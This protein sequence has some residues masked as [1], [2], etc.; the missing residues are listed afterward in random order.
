M[1]RQ[2][3]LVGS[4]LCLLATSA[5]FAQDDLQLAATP[6]VIDIGALYNGTTINASGVAPAD[7]E[8]VLRFLGE[9]HDVHMKE[10]GRV[11]GV[12]WMN[13][14]SLTFMGVPN[15]C[16]VSSATNLD[17]LAGNGDPGPGGS[18]VQGL[19]LTGIKDSARIESK[20][21]DEAVA[22]GEFLKLKQVRLPTGGR[23]SGPKFPYHRACRRAHT[24]WR[25]SRCAMGV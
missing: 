11:F 9:P 13:L 22:F 17:G 4:M 19:G 15:V 25:P 12:M 5:A 3:F 21:M 8:I 2:T 24:V 6:K 20:G 14:D 7:S 16:I 18:A 10:K 23:V 1:I